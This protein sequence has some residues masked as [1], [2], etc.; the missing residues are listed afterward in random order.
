MVGRGWAW[1]RLRRAAAGCGGLRRAQHLPKR[2][3]THHPGQGRVEA[4]DPD[5]MC[6]RDLAKSGFAAAFKFGAGRPAVRVHR[7]EL[8]YLRE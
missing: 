7:F 5:P 1:Q 3:A 6:P 4:H 8:R 2:T